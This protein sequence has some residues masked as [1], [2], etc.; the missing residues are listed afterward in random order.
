VNADYLRFDFSH[1]AKVT[2]EELAQIEAIVNEKIRENIPVVIKELPREE[3]LK[4]GA[5]ALF[6]EKYGETVRVVT[7]DPAYSIELCGGTHVGSTGELGL[8]KFT[9][10]SAVAAGVRRIEAVT[11]A[12]AEAYVTEH[13]QQ[14]KE[15]KGL[16]KNPKDLIKA[17][18]QLVNDKASLE[19]QLAA[20]ELKQVQ[21]QA[22]ALPQKAVTVNGVHFLGAIVEAGN[23]EMLK[24]FALA[25]KELLT[26]PYMAV[27]CANVGGKAQVTVLVDE[28]LVKE[29]GFN[30][31][32][33]I[34]EQVAPLIK[35]GGGGQP[36]LAS[37]GGQDAG[38]LEQVIEKVKELL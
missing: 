14:L 13:L 28:Q 32:K 31:Q 15:V 17:I 1:F 35:G 7:I 22:T 9:A 18:D 38:Q 37:A 5:M 19:K 24:Q 27:L 11:G 34:K 26:S 25:V 6:G 8:F 21:Q 30:A 36:A 12:K 29:K 4:L 10:E 33:I 20:L 16:L 23:A 2:D 3:A